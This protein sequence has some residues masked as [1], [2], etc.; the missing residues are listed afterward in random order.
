MVQG[1]ERERERGN[2]C[3]KFRLERERGYGDSKLR[4]KDDDDDV[5]LRHLEHLFYMEKTTDNDFPIH[6]PRSKLLH[7]LLL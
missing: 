7:T 1:R 2:V 5:H 4:R 6:F 3:R